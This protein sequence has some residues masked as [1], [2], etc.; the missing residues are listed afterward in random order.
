LVFGDFN[1]KNEQ[2]VKFRLGIQI[3]K[4]EKRDPFVSGAEGAS[5]RQPPRRTLVA[6]RRR[7]PAL[8]A[9]F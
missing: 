3:K 6:G 8:M 7:R 9:E 1:V 4:E 2:R 5:S